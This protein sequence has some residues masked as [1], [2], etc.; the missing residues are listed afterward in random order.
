MMNVLAFFS[1]YGML[2]VMFY[3]PLYMI[4]QIV[5]GEFNGNDN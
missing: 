2:M 3:V 5:D 1:L 4:I